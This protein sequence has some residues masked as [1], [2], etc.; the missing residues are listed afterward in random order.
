[1][2]SWTKVVSF[3]VPARILL[4][5]LHHISFAR[6]IQYH[7]KISSLISSPSRLF[8]AKSF[9][10][11]ATKKEEDEEEEKGPVYSKADEVELP[12]EK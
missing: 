8:L 3:K 1:M 2:F 12:M 10:S 11:T 9:S 5:P 6:P 4:S 7:L